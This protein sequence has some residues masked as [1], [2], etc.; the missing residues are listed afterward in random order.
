[1]FCL[2]LNQ[3]KTANA[4]R[5]EPTKDL[6]EIFRVI[7][8]CENAV[9]QLNQYIPMII[10][11]GE[12]VEQLQNISQLSK[13]VTDLFVST[14]VN[15]TQEDVDELSSKTDDLKELVDSFLNNFNRQK[16]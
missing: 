9:G 2:I 5:K 3:E 16:K 10:R 13:D 4:D 12:L 14:G 7:K 8:Y 15:S 6:G 11:H 1:M